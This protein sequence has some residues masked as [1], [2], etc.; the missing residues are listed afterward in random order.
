MDPRFSREGPLPGPT[1]HRLRRL[2]DALRNA[3]RQEAAEGR[4]L[5]LEPG[6]R[7]KG[8]TGALHLLVLSAFGVAQPLFAI[9]RES[10]EFFVARRVDG[11]ELVAFTAILLVLPPALAMACVWVADAVR[12]RWSWH[13]HRLFVG[14]FGGLTVLTSLGRMSTGSAL[15]LAL[16][17][18]LV[19]SWAYRPSSRLGS[20][21]SLGAPAP[22]LFASAFLLTA[23]I[24]ALVLGRSTPVVHST[25]PR[26]T[27]P[28]V[29]VV[30]DELPAVSLL[31]EDGRINARRFPNLAALSARATWFPTTGTVHPFSS[32]AVPA[33]LTGSIPP[34]D[35]AP[36]STSYPTNLFTVLGTSH[37]V[38]AVEPITQLCPPNLCPLLPRVRH[39][40]LRNMASLLAVSSS[41]YVKATLP[42]SSWSSD[43]G[44]PFGQLLDLPAQASAEQEIPTADGNGPEV[45]NRSAQFRRFLDALHPG[46]RQLYFA[47]VLL[48]HAPFEHLPSGTRYHHVGSVL[49]GLFDDH[50]SS[51]EP[52]LA[53]FSRRRH[54]LQLRHVDQLIGELVARL[55]ALEM[56]DETLL[57][58][59]AD[60]GVSFEPG[61]AHR[62]V[63]EDNKYDIGLVPLIIKAPFQM[64]ATVQPQPVRTIDVLPTILGLL[65]IGVPFQAD[66]HDALAPGAP[67]SALR[68]RDTVRDTWVDLDDG[69]AELGRAGRRLAQQLGDG[70]ST[71][72]LY[73]GGPHGDLVG[74]RAADL[75]SEG[76]L[77]LLAS[78]T[79]GPGFDSV[80]LE[81]GVVPALMVGRLPGPVPPGTFVAVAVNGTV[82]AVVPTYADPDGARFVALLPDYLFVDGSNHVELVTVLG[83]GSERRFLNLSFTAGDASPEPDSPQPSEVV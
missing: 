79:A 35:A 19:L 81:G 46:D 77:D 34:E 76:E 42:K 47:H 13:V 9:L 82:G 51:D 56:F 29:F 73:D 72:D 25:Q 78:L 57:V 71:Y 11:G 30:F 21:L 37:E 28:V 45:L 15:A 68:V 48:P 23:P 7:V 38:N 64:V 4:P 3:F 52:W 61:G 10:P 27:N 65:D 59:T 6:R 83:S 67:R 26:A 75:P 36:T 63:T 44:D 70:T 60:H 16:S 66:G 17:A 49:E 69:P 1:R 39:S 43:K 12:P 20:F 53:E 2:P 54:M 32:H 41:V 8:R 22:A 24:S 74:S 50:W 40:R 33:L 18:G 80:D 14:V 58:I 5:P 31:D 62:I 55:D